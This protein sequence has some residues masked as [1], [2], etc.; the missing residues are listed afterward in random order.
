MKK[1]GKQKISIKK[2]TIARISVGSMKKIEGG[3][4]ILTQTVPEV[5]PNGVVEEHVCYEVQ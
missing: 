5:D 1:D 3:T 2:L 4:S